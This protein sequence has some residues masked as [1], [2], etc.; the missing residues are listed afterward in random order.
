MS[1]FKSEEQHK[2]NLKALGRMG[3]IVV[4]YFVL[5]YLA[6]YTNIELY[7]MRLPWFVIV[8]IVGGFYIVPRARAVMR[9]FEDNMKPDS[10]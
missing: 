8:I 2:D 10:E 3:G 4:L 5:V 1:I 7:P 9:A 6:V